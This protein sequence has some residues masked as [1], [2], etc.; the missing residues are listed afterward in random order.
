M[1]V[2]TLNVTKWGG[3]KYIAFGK[4]LWLKPKSWIYH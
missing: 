1:N 2:T 3:K 4:G